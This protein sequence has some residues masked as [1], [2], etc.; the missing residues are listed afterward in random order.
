MTRDAAENAAATLLRRL[1]QLERRDAERAQRPELARASAFLAQWQMRRLRYTYADFERSPRYAPAIRFFETDLYGG[2]T[3]DDRDGDIA[4]V[5]PSMKRLLP[6]SV[7]ET[8]ADAIELRAI[9]QQLDRVMVE[10]LMPLGEHL[11]V[12]DYC[13]AYRAAG[14]YPSRQRQIALVAGVGRALDRYVQQPLIRGA[15]RMMRRPARVAGLSGLQD[16]LERGFAA[17]A[18]MRGADEFIATIDARE[19]ALHEAIAGGACDPFPDP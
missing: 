17:F 19:T 12:C 2:S 6:T 1:Q 11:G 9:A 18:R 16:F 14:E 4:R 7:F 3:L 5:V 8:V 13:N 15:L 10:R